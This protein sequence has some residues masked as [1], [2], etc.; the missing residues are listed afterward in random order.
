[1]WSFSSIY[2]TDKFLQLVKIAIFR[3]WAK[4]RCFEYVALNASEL[5]LPEKKA[6]LQELQ[7]RI[8]SAS[9]FKWTFHY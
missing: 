6:E 1:M 8:S 5:L 3:V 9:L 2:P 7:L 4:T